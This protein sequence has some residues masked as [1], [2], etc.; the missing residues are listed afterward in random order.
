MHI[1]GSEGMAFATF[2]KLLVV[3]YANCNKLVIFS[4][5]AKTICVNAISCTVNICFVYLL[6]RMIIFP[7]SGGRAGFR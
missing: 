5:R 3:N 4:C 6:G 2:A 7:G 1:M